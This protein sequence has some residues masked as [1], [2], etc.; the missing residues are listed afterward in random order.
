LLYENIEYD[1][2]YKCVDHDLKE[3]IQHGT[4]QNLKSVTRYNYQKKALSLILC[5]YPKGSSI[6][7][8]DISEN[9]KIHVYHCSYSSPTTPSYTF[10]DY[11]Y[12]LFW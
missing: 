5:H 7:E 11:I 10:S 4:V 2:F 3:V 6:Y 1:V 12:C 9:L 8:S